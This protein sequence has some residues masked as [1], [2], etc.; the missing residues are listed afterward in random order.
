MFSKILVAYDGSEGAKLALTK[1]REIAQAAKADL[2]RR[3]TEEFDA[4][5]ARHLPETRP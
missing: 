5:L 4:L 2:R 1:G 3:F